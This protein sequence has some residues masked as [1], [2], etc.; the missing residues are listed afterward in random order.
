MPN[1]TLLY[2][3]IPTHERKYILFTFLI[4]E[5]FIYILFFQSSIECA[6]RAE[7][8]ADLTLVS[9]SNAMR[10]RVSEKKEELSSINVELNKLK[11][12]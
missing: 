10:R 12:V 7:E 8:N 2:T 9:K 5:I 6:E 1:F 11:S 4:N 3:T